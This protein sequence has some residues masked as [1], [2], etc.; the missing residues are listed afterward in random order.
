MVVCT[1]ASLKLIDRYLLLPAAAF[2]LWGRKL[3]FY[4]SLQ[5]AQTGR[6]R[7]NG[8]AGLVFCGYFQFMPRSIK[9][10]GTDARH[11]PV[12]P[13]AR[14]SKLPAARQ[15]RSGKLYGCGEM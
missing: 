12:P 9:G 2:R 3:E 7:T 1:A 5:F 8:R 13:T 6:K 10:E 14:P 11:K 15:P 4:R